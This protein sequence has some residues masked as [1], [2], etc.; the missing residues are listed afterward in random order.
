MN[1]SDLTAYARVYDKNDNNI[2]TRNNYYP[3][4][5]IS[6]VHIK[7]FRCLHDLPIPF[8]NLTALVGRNGSG[9]SSVL[10]AIDIFYDLSYS[11]LLEDYC[12][13]GTANPIEIIVTFREFTHHEEILFRDFIS[14]ESLTVTKRMT[15]QDGNPTIGYYASK[16]QI[17]E[18]TQIRN[19]SQ[20]RARMTAIRELINSNQF[21]DLSGTFRSE[22][23]GLSILSNYEQD[24]PD[25]TILIE[26][27]V[28][29]MGARNVGGGRL[30][31]YTRFIM[32][33]A[34]KEV[35]DE[36]KGRSSPIGNLINAIVSTEIE[37]RDDLLEFKERINREIAEMYA[38]AHRTGALY[39]RTSPPGWSTRT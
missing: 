10:K 2:I 34:V 38:R 21:E 12:N 14:D 5:K 4:M 26:S 11:V 30:D 33:P 17:P 22:A 8:E 16:N 35:T 6:N 1:N 15:W 23:D 37:N 29:F 19:L 39:P 20:P 36:L 32:L 18:F 13:R 28:Q 25:L 7:N 3:F 27:R 24:H 9:K 31:N